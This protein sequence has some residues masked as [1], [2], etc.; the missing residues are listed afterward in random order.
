MEF[1]SYGDVKANEKLMA[2]IAICEKRQ[3]P[4]KEVYV[5]PQGQKA[6]ILRT[7]DTSVT[8]TI[9]VEGHGD[10]LEWTTTRRNFEAKWKPF[11]SECE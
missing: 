6:T 11:V 10:A 7:T 1:V 9:S 3:K 8:F 2:A 4:S 5:G